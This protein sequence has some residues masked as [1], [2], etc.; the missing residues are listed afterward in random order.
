MC[1]FNFSLQSDLT[2]F[3]EALKTSESRP[4]WVLLCFRPGPLVAPPQR[5]S[6]V[7]ERPTWPTFTH[8]TH[9]VPLEMDHFSLCWMTKWE[10]K[11]K[12]YFCRKTCC[13]RKNQL[14]KNETDLSDLVSEH[15]YLLQNDHG[16]GSSPSECTLAATWRTIKNM[17]WATWTVVALTQT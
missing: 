3:A 4:A 13:H 5:S 12:T 10:Q 7:S 9:S 17:L 8:K 14:P 11:Q 15:V 2:L 1:L 6:F 16:S